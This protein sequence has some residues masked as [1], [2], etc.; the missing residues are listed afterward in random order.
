MKRLSKIVCSLLTLVLLSTLIPLSP[1][2]SISVIADGEVEINPT[3]FPDDN[4]RKY[5]SANCDTN[6]DAKLSEAELNAVVGI[7]VNNYN[8]SD[9]TGVEYFTALEEYLYCDHNQLT[10]LDVSK[11]V[12]L[13]ELSCYDNQLTSLDVSKNAALEILWCYDNKLTNGE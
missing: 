4:F 13:R 2:F 3:N 9:L 10:S 12:A 7:D 1:L 11:N 6:H 5:V 8:I